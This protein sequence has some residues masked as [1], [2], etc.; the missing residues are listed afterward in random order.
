MMRELNINEIREVNGG[1]RAT[2]SCLR[3]S[4]LLGISPLGGPWAV[5]GAALGAIDAC[6]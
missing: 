2:N 5:A 6:T 3:W 1:A 4:I